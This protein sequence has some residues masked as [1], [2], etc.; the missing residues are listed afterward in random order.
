MRKRTESH[1]YT[2]INTKASRATAFNCGRC[3][4][5]PGGLGQLV[6]QACGFGGPFLLLWS[7]TGQVEGASAAEM[8]GVLRELGFVPNFLWKL[9]GSRGDRG[10]TR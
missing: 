1:S 7:F 3:A 6:A 9:A 5:L 8:M 10:S 2:K 4:L